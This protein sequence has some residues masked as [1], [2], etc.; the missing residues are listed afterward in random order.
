MND[1]QEDTAKYSELFQPKKAIKVIKKD[2]SLEAFNVQ[3][4]IDAVGKSA[5]RAL[6]RF[7]EEEKGVSACFTGGCSLCGAYFLFLMTMIR[8]I[9]MA[10]TGAYR[11]TTIVSHKNQLAIITYNPRRKNSENRSQNRRSHTASPRQDL[12]RR[13]STLQTAANKPSLFCLLL[14]RSQH[15]R[16]GQRN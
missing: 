14:S 1:V 9:G 12:S 13:S 3:K 16:R 11:M 15:I 6:T 10:A 2:G 5:Y 8:Q 7:T 4:V